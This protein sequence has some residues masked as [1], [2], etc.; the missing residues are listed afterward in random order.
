MGF[1]AIS[2]SLIKNIVDE[3]AMF[4]LPAVGA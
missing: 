4:P 1:A 3:A 2:L